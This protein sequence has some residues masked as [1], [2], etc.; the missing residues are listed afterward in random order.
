MGWGAEGAV[1]EDVEGALMDV[2]LSGADEE[3]TDTRHTRVC[4]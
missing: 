2:E 4:V 1:R 3:Q